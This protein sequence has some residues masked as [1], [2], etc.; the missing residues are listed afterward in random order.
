MKKSIQK[1]ICFAVLL[2]LWLFPCLKNDFYVKDIIGLAVFVLCMLAVCLINGKIIP[3]LFSAVLTLAVS[4]YNEEYFY[5][6]ALPL[7]LYISAEIA[8]GEAVDKKKKDKGIFGLFITGIWII[9][10]IE[11]VLLLVSGKD[12]HSFISALRIVKYTVIYFVLFAL[13]VIAAFLKN[14]KKQKTKDI[15]Y[16]KNIRKIFITAVFALSLS[17][18]YFLQHN[19]IASETRMAVDFMYWFIFMGVVLLEPKGIIKHIFTDS[20]NM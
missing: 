18:V 4:L 19:S 20:G 16:L 3:V 1:L 11:A 12:V 6:A 5:Y 2:I 17:L 9:L 8:F 7:A 10:C 13:I 15:P 14:H